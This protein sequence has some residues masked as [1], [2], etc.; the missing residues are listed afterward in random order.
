MKRNDDLL[1]E[2]LF[3][4]E[5]DENDVLHFRK[6]LSMPQEQI[7]RNHH[8]ALLSDAGL[9]SQVSDTGFRLTNM[10]HDYIVAIR[11]DTI[12]NKT[13]SAVGD[14]GGATLGM[15][16]DIAIAYLKQEATEKLGI[17]F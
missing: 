9:V 17:N 14:L 13:K 8:V 6:Y 1:R 12:W 16:K 5:S 7:E 15:V 2:L 11:D 10:G 4:F 3:E